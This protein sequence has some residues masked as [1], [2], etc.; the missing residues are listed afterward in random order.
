MNKMPGTDMV[1]DYGVTAS[2]Q[3]NIRLTL[4]ST[5]QTCKHTTQFQIFIQVTPNYTCLSYPHFP[6]VTVENIHEYYRNK[7]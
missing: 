4:S 7:R 1:S 2:S 3:E 5:L 6:K